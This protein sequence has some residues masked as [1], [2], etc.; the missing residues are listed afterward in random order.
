M[1]PEDNTEARGAQTENEGQA[2]SIQQYYN[3][4]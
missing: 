4:S 3:D 1:D 2:V